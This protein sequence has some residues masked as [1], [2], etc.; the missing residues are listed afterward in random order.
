MLNLTTHMFTLTT[1][2]VANLYCGKM[3]MADYLYEISCNNMKYYISLFLITV[4]LCY[5]QIFAQN[6]DTS[7]VYLQALRLHFF[8]INKTFGDRS[9]YYLE[10]D[11]YTTEGLPRMIDGQEIEALTRK[12]IFE[13]T[14]K[15][16]IGLITIRPARW[17]NDGLVINVIDFVVSTKRKYFFKRGKHFFYSNSGGSSFQ[18]LGK[19]KDGLKLKIL[20][21]GGI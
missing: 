5:S 16:S 20:H 19:E 1:H 4:F 6:V 2:K 15:Q 21:Q 7:N 18:I 3:G 17:T 14:K 13:K 8:Y 10:Q 11:V 12:A 9:I